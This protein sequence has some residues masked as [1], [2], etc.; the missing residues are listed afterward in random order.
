MRRW[1]APSY[2]ELRCQLVEADS[3]AARDDAREPRALRVAYEAAT[4]L[5]VV[6]LVDGGSFSFPPV[7]C[8]GLAGAAAQDLADVHPTPGGFGLHW[9]SLDVLVAVPAVMAGVFGSEA[10]MAALREL[11][12]Q[13]GGAETWLQRGPSGAAGDEER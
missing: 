13:L 11:S 7:L 2:A 5:V 6:E 10:W 8:Q 3:R 9:R 1:R 12:D 4:G